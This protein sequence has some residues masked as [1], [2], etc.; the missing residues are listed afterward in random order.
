M[1]KEFFKRLFCHH[2][3]EQ[4]AIWEFS[5]RIDVKRVCRKCGKEQ[6]EIIRY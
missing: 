6:W 5:D 4:M 3:Y 2:N 1:I